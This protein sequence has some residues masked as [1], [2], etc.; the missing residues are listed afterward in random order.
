MHGQQLPGARQR[1]TR[2]HDSTR[3]IWSPATSSTPGSPYGGS[4]SESD[5]AMAGATQ[6]GQPPAMAGAA[7]T[8]GTGTTSGYGSASSGYGAGTA[9]GYGAVPA[10]AAAAVLRQLCPAAG[11]S[12]GPCHLRAQP[13]RIAIR[14]GLPGGPEAMTVTIAAAGAA[15][16]TTPSNSF[17]DTRGAAAHRRRE[18]PSAEQQSLYTRRR[19][20]L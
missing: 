13:V 18:Q 9:S 6:F 16:S 11:S 1:H 8:Y 7:S 17:A 12:S 10:T 4:G 2:L 3:R 14:S 5:T 20:G 15:P 19:F